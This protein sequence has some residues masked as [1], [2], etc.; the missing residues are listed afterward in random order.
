MKKKQNK[1]FNAIAIVMA[2]AIILPSIVKFS[3][4]F[5]HHEHAVCD[6]KS[7]VHFHETDVD[8]EFYKFKL[9]KT[10]Y[11]SLEY[12]EQELAIE[13]SKEVLS[14]YSFDYFHKQLSSFLRG[15]PGLI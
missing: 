10:L 9:N 15:P 12:S 1:V 7:K 11:L 14:D 3:H 8:C 6:V 2:I 4:A 13:Q 5:T